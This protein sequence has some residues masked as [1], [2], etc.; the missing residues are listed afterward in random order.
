MV[1][2]YVL[3]NLFQVLSPVNCAVFC[4]LRLFIILINLQ[5]IYNSLLFTYNIRSLCFNL[6]FPMKWIL[7][8]DFLFFDLSLMIFIVSFL[9]LCLNTI[10]RI[11]YILSWWSISIKFCGVRSHMI[12]EGV[13]WQLQVVLMTL[14][15]KVWIIVFSSQISFFGFKFML[16]LWSLASC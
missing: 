5:W 10:R 7:R 14:V 9:M 16:Y 12:C 1:L 13:I 3:F 15:N 8:F 11:S 2:I 6:L 4:G